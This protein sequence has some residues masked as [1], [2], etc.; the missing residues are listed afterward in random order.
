LEQARGTNCA[1]SEARILP[2]A[3]RRNIKLAEA[4]S[5]GQTIFEYAPTCH[6]AEDYQKVAEFLLDEE[7]F[8]NRVEVPQFE[9]QERDVAAAMDEQ[10][11]SHLGGKKEDKPI[12]EIA[13]IPQS[14]PSEE[15]VSDDVS[16]QG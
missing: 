14:Q 3:I 5:Y 15:K 13:E 10:L 7:G 2:V 4:P 9:Q 12:A 6:G 11:E 8:Y 16:Q 1:W